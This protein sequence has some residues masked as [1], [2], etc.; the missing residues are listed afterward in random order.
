VSEPSAER[1]ALPE[2]G[3][4]LVRHAVARFASRS[5]VAM[6]LLAIGIVFA[7]QQIAQDVAL[8]DA[9]YR[10]AAVAR[11]LSGVMG[12][13]L[14]EGDPQARHQV[15]A[16][17]APIL[18]NQTMTH[19][20][21]W[22]EDGTVL[23]ADDPALVG[24]TFDLE[25]D[26]VALFGTERGTADLSG[27]DRAENVREQEEGELLEVYVGA[28]D[29]AGEPWVFEAY[30]S[31]EA[32]RRNHSTIL[33]GM[34]PLALG[35]ILLLQIAVLPLAL[36][37]ARRVQK[38]QAERGRWLRH[39]LLASELERRRIAK[40]L[41]DGVVQD[42]AGLSLALP[43]VARRLP[44]TEDAA[45]ARRA[46]DRVGAVLAED[47]PA[48][49]SMMTDIYPPDLDG[50]GLLV[51]I[52]ELA[53]RAEEAGLA[54]SIHVDAGFS[55]PPD[56]GRLVY[57]VVREGLR[58]AVSHAPASTVRVSLRELETDVLVEVVDS[59][60][61]LPAE[62]GQP[63]T[64]HLG[65]QLLADTVH[66]VGGRLELRDHPAGGAVLRVV[67]PVHAVPL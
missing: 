33:A 34:L 17:L 8:E 47:V 27:L 18:H 52:E 28:I 37:L 38:A 64:G 26:V 60:P 54:V 4:N 14:R 44:A 20:K 49:R 6:L 22:S 32:M 62:R 5:L 45:D 12:D 50:S 39:A 10:S 41:H 35:G 40:D 31:T 25:P 43:V 19:I 58:N 1:S 51:A 46:L 24:R 66:D 36:S 67:F 16:A 65:L 13:G 11:G 23:W 30:L 42:L 57:R 2:P 55:V 63:A 61:G 7:S 48:L 15:A 3:P 29:S 56:T 59:G 9:T 21:L 53:D